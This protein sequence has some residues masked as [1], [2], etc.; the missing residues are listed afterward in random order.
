MGDHVLTLIAYVGVGVA[1]GWWFWRANAGV[2]NSP[3]HAAVSVLFGLLWPVSLPW[4]ALVRATSQTIARRRA[5]R[6][7]AAVDDPVL[8]T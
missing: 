5:R 8:D 7:H 4:R 1:T 6:A 2:L 3:A